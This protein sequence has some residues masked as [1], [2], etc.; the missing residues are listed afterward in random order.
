V[1]T[2]VYEEVFVEIEQANLMLSA[3]YKQWL[4]PGFGGGNFIEE[5]TED[6]DIL[7]FRFW[8]GNPVNGGLVAGSEGFPQISFGY[9]G[10]PEEAHFKGIVENSD[11]LYQGRLLQYQ[12]TNSVKLLPA[13]YRCFEGSLTVNSHY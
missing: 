3:G 8:Y 12:K 10:N 13:K 5:Y 2:E 1:D 6:Y 11:A 7:P 9:R 4:I